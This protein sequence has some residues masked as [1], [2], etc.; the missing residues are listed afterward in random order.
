MDF[1]RLNVDA[2]PY[3]ITYAELC[4][5]NFTIYRIGIQDWQI[6]YDIMAHFAHYS[7]R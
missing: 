4:K 1:L 6:I 7:L 2:M 3:T 5:V